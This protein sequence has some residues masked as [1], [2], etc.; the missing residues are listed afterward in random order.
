MQHD[1]HSPEG[2]ERCGV[3]PYFDGQRCVYFLEGGIGCGKSTVI[4][5]CPEAFAC[6]RE[7]LDVWRTL[8]YPRLAYESPA[9]HAWN[10]QSLVL[11]TQQTDLVTALKTDAKTIVVERS[12]LSNA[13]FAQLLHEDGYI[14]DL[15]M[16]IYRQQHKAAAF[17]MHDLLTRGGFYVEHIWLDVSPEECLNRLNHRNKA[18]GDKDG[19]SAVDYTYQTR[20]FLKHRNLFSK[21]TTCLGNVVRLNNMEP[22]LVVF[23]MEC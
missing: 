10:F 23:K 4:D 19:E 12:V 21:P 22:E 15:Q 16:G 9:E 20:L 11:A 3:M 8:N 7:N 13:I 2:P 6:V 18:R 17:A 1:T 5:A 14:S